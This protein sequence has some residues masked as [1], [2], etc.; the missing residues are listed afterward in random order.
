MKRRLVHSLKREHRF[1]FFFD[2][3][4]LDMDQHELLLKNDEHVLT[5]P[6]I[7]VQFAIR[8]TGHSV[9]T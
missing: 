3:S 7:H 4:I 1:F 6:P 2:D 8:A 9:H 5:M